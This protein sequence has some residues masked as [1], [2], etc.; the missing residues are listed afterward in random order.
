MANNYT[1]TLASLVPGT[2]AKSS[3]INE[4]YD[5]TVSAFD[6]LPA[7]AIGKKGFSDPVPVGTPTAPDHATTKDYVDNDLQSSVNVAGQYAASSFSSAEQAGTFLDGAIAAEANAATSETNAANSAAYSAEWANKAVDTLV[8]AAAGGDQIDDYSAMH[9]ATKAAISESNAAASESNAATSESNASTSAANAATSATNAATSATNAGLSASAAQTAQTAAESAKTA[10]ETAQINTQNIFDAFGDQYAGPFADDASANS[11]L[12]AALS[13]GDLYF[14]TTDNELRWYTGTAWTAPSALANASATAAATSESNAA[15]SESNAATSASN[16]ATSETNAATSASN[17]STSETNAGVSES[18]AATSASNAA[19][20]EGNAAD[21][22][23]D[24]Q[25]LATNAEDVQYTLS[26]TVT[27]GF[28]ALH[29]AAKASASAS[30]ASTSESNASTS[31]SNA[32]TSASNASTSEGNAATSATS[33][34]TSATNAGTSA[35]NAANSA[36]AASSSETNA[37]NSASAAQTA[38]TAAELAWDTFDDRYLGP[39]ASDPSLDNDGDTLT[40]GALYWNTTS[41]EMRAYNGSIWVTAYNDGTVNATAVVYSNTTSGLTATNAQGAI[42]EI[43]NTL[44]NLT[45]D[46]LANTTISSNTDGE[47]LRWNGVAWV[48]NTLAE[49]GIQP[50]G[51]YL[52]SETSH[53]DVLVDGDFASQGFMYRGATV[54][55]YSIKTDVLVDGDFTQ[56][57]FMKRT[58][59]GSYTVDTNTYS[60]SS[61]THTATNISYSNGTSGLTANNIQD[62]VDELASNPAGGSETLTLAAGLGNVAQG[63][64]LVIASNGQAQPVKALGLSWANNGNPQ[65]SFNSNGHGYAESIG[66]STYPAT[67]IVTSGGGTDVYPINWASGG[68]HSFGGP[69][70]N[71]ENNPGSWGSIACNIND[72]YVAVY[73][74]STNQRI[75]AKLV[76]ASGSLAAGPLV[77]VESSVSNTVEG[78]VI[79]DQATDRFVA[80]WLDA[81]NFSLQCAVGKITGGTLTFATPFSLGFANSASNLRLVGANDGYA[82]VALIGFLGITKC[83]IQRIKIDATTE[84]VTGNAFQ[85]NYFQNGYNYFDIGADDDSGNCFW[86]GAAGTGAGVKL[87][88]FDTDLNAIYEVTVDTYSSGQSSTPIIAMPS[89]RINAAKAPYIVWKNWDTNSNQALPILVHDGLALADTSITPTYINSHDLT[90][91]VGSTT[92][93]TTEGIFFYYAQGQGYIGSADLTEPSTTLTTTV[94]GTAATAA[95]AGGSVEMRTSAFKQSGYSGL[96]IGSKYYVNAVG[97]LSASGNNENYYVGYAISSTELLIKG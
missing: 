80:A 7:P 77:T 46:A 37:A 79:Y 92:D 90:W 12:G 86:I 38:Q 16:A 95:T 14:N 54:G 71:L 83:A 72:E 61:H 67:F 25:K 43:D 27:T 2:T 52:T 63:D 32:A 22:K 84:T 62:A 26:D 74:D 5:N 49:A 81:N 30:A 51:S 33:A 66:G 41:N 39:K 24:A 10:A 76:T 45:L 91:G 94:H 70:L 78:R 69:N 87:T 9:H 36:L 65:S 21:S 88:T 42:D 53:A 3:D 31:E 8:S 11:A 17:A 23:A 29:Y 93:T 47:I 97:E 89:R 64:P 6:K 55:S 96:T 82:Y 28:S 19:I 58:G 59:A 15:T 50:A 73:H 68:S 44:D 4:R 85:T 57:G 40:T 60:L 13:I 75:S 1:P 18:N 20:Y 48:N 56:N 35:T 34:S